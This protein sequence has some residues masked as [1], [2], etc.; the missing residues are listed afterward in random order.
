M[1][2]QL[3]TTNMLGYTELKLATMQQVSCTPEQHPQRILSADVGLIQLPSHLC[4]AATS[5]LQWNWSNLSSI[6][7]SDKRSGMR[8]SSWPR[9]I[10]S[11][12]P[13]AG[14]YTIHSNSFSL[15]LLLSSFP[16]PSLSLWQCTIERGPYTPNQLPESDLLPIFLH[17]FILPCQCLHR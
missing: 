16:C 2:Q 5:S 3:P 10:F 1:A 14:R 12:F 8:Q 4:P 7:R 11:V 9:T 13:V 17:P 15:S 6:Y